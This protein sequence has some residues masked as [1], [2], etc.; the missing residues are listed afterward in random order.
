VFKGDFYTSTGNN[1]YDEIENK[2]TNNINGFV[3]DVD[4]KEYGAST[5]KST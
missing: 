2:N 4:N 5:D 3:Q 1:I